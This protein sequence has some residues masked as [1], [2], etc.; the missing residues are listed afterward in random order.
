MKWLR[1]KPAD[2]NELDE[3]GIYHRRTTSPCDSSTVQEDGDGDTEMGT[4]PGPSQQSTQTVAGSSPIGQ[5]KK[6]QVRKR[7]TG[8]GSGGVGIG[9]GPSNGVKMDTNG[10]GEGG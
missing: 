1:S 10:V 9:I 4:V 5:R 8:H 3:A 2:I 7:K 6:A